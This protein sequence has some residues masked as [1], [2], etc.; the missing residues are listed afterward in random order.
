MTLNLEVFAIF[1]SPKTISYQEM[2]I[3]KQIKHF[4]CKDN[5]DICCIYI[6]KVMLN[7]PFFTVNWLFVDNHG[8]EK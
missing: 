2:K 4:Y 7:I 3:Y 8:P 1:F 5:L 6:S